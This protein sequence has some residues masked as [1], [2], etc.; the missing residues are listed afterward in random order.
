[1]RDP[2]HASGAD[3]I[4][5]EHTL[6]A[7]ILGCGSSAGVPR[8]GGADGSGD[9]GACDPANPKNHRRRCSLL[10]RRGGTTVLVDTSPDLREQLL[11]ARC[12]HIDG[13]L[14]THAHADQTNGIDDLRPLTFI[15]RRRIPMY[16]DRATMA[17]LKQQFAYCFDSMHD[18]PA[19][20]APHDIGEPFR[21]F[22]IEG[23]GGPVPVL[24]FWQQHGPVRSLGY[25]FGGLAYSSDVSELDEIA[26]AALQGIDTW[27]LDAL[28]YRE[29]PTH[30]N[31]D[32]AL[33]WIERVKPRQA[34]LTNFNI[35]IDYARLAAELPPGIVPA[36]DGLIVSAPLPWISPSPLVGEGARSV[37][38]AREWRAEGGRRK[39]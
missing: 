12:R 38:K 39:T 31:V 17:H 1:M 5:T 2:T 21:P 22:E 26:F 4:K 29:H 10:V 16:G 18:Y 30:A 13:V 37:P 20:I 35:D 32:T 23:E 11:S 25:R 33:R 36:F 27:I 9:W 24:A 19:I 28:R 14:M 7:I 15:S 3:S 8:L 6:E 34:I